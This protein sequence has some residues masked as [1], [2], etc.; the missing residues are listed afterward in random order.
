MSLTHSLALTLIAAVLLRISGEPLTPSSATQL[1]S[2]STSIILG[3]DE[4]TGKNATQGAVGSRISPLMTY[5][6]TLKNVV[7]F[8]C[9]LTALLITCLV[10]KVVRTGRKIRKTRKYDIIT[11]P[12]ERVEMAPLN[13]E[14]DDEDDST[15][16]DV[17]YR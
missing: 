7:I 17:K 10:I 12:A 13:E 1:N 14:N 9:V 11:T 3:H 4:Q 16:F 5:L 2:T 6:P 8:I 15:L